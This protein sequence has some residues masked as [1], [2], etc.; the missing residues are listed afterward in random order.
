MV[1]I[2]S[3]EAT[4]APQ[5]MP[6]HHKDMGDKMGPHRGGNYSTAGSPSIPE[7]LPGGPARTKREGPR[8]ERDE[9]GYQGLDLKSIY[10]KCIHT[11]HMLA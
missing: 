9:G 3:S 1:P 6:P 11:I 7:K 8:N 4:M 5:S 10:Q 2:I